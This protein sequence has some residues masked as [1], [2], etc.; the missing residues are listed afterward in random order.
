MMASQVALV[1][2]AGT[3]LI[4]DPGFK[5]VEYLAEQGHYVTSL[6]GP[7]AVIAA[8]TLAGLPT[9]RFYF[10]GL[11]P[12]QKPGPDKHGLKQKRTSVAA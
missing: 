11:Q 10:F 12:Q 4:S 7:S 6:P 1:S 3:P 5:L 9:D 2:D 8:L